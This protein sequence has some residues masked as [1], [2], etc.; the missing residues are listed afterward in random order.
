[1]SNPKTGRH[2]Y[3]K[4]TAC[5]DKPLDNRDI[6]RN[7]LA[8]LG[9]TVPEDTDLPRSRTIAEVVQLAESRRTRLACPGSTLVV[10]GALAERAG[11]ALTTRRGRCLWCCCNCA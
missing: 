3:R 11:G 9:R 2:A 4:E 8:R 10:T 7:L 5:K 6:V 1:M